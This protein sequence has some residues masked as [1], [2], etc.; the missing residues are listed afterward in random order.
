MNT[1]KTVLKTAVAVIL[2]MAGFSTVK[3]Q[4]RVGTNGNFGTTSNVPLIFDVN[5]VKAGSTGSSSNSNVSFGYE[6]HLN[7]TTGSANTAI[8]FKALRNTTGGQNAAF[9]NEALT[10]NTSGSY[11]TA[12]GFLCAKNQ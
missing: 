12:F 5:N 3:A 4:L 7:T 11:N 10:T 1:K 6:A 8:G 2:V 9:G